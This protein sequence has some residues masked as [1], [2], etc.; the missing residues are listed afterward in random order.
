MNTPQPELIIVPGPIVLRGVVGST[1]HGLALPGKDDRDEMGVCVESA[2]AVFDVERHYEQTI[3]R[4]AAIREHRHDAPSQ[5]GDL[6][7]VVYSLRKYCRLACKGNP[8]ILLLLYLPEYVKRTPLGSDLLALRCSIV[9]RAA[10]QAFRG[11]LIAQRQRL[12]GQRGQRDVNRP[13]LEAAHGYDTKYAMHMLRLGY[14]GKEL[15]EDGFL[16][17][18]MKEPVR[19]RLMRVREGKELMSDVLDEARR[20]EGEMD[21][22][23]QRSVLRTEPDTR[24]VSMFLRSAYLRAWD[25]NEY[26]DGAYCVPETI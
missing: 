11:Y 17:L 9:S 20:L 10:G 5:P 4:T 2:F 13:A 14:Q 8:T 1:A 21:E 19:S 18:P 24:A 22:A 16:T 25:D 7:L 15:M 26:A 3:H 23:I 6:D 12:L